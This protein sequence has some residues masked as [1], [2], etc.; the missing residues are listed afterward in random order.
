MLAYKILL[1]VAMACL[2]SSAA[3]PKPQEIVRGAF[4]GFQEV[5]QPV[6]DLEALFGQGQFQAIWNVD[7]ECNPNPFD[8]RSTLPREGKDV[9]GA[10]FRFE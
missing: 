7:M 5:T 10:D 3:I 1:T 4:S 9:S 2:A 8:W 6:V